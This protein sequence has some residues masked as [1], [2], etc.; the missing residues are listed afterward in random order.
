MFI[1]LFPFIFPSSFPFCLCACMVTCGWLVEKQS[2]H[3]C[4]FFLWYI[5]IIIY[6]YIYLERNEVGEKVWVRREGKREHLY[7]SM[8]TMSGEFNPALISR[9]MHLKWG[10]IMLC[11][12]LPL[13]SDKWA[14]F[15]HFMCKCLLKKSAKSKKELPWHNHSG[16]YIYIYVYIYMCV[17]TCL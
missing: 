14:T 9:H 16:E 7:W 12:V 8:I 6:I 2:L 3:W 17:W 4:T 5:S 1:S 13:F 11:T 15:A 10:I